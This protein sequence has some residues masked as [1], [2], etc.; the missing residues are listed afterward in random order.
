VPTYDIH[1]TVTTHHHITVAGVDSPSAAMDHVRRMDPNA[2][3]RGQPTGTTAMVVEAT[4]T[5]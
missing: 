5:S 2:I 4:P 1:V 3:R